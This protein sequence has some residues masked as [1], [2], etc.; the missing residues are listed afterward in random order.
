MQNNDL[1]KYSNMSKYK[2]HIVLE[3]EKKNREYDKNYAFE[4]PEYRKKCKKNLDSFRK[5]HPHYA[6]DYMRRVRN[7]KIKEKRN[8]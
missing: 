2:K 3:K 5:K 8:S 7:D 4:H 1:D 6:R